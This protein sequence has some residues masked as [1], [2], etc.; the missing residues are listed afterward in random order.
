[1]IPCSPAPLE[2]EPWQREL[3]EAITDPQQLL[4]LLG[5][6]DRLSNAVQGTPAA[7][8]LRVPRY[9]AGLMRRGDPHDPLL[10]QVLPLRAEQYE[11]AGYRQD[12]VGDMAASLD[13]GILKK[14]RGRALLVTTGACAVHCRYCFRRHFPYA[15]QAL[16]RHWQAALHTLGQLPDIDELI[17]SGGDP[18]TLSDRRLRGLLEDAAQLSQLRRLRIHTRLPVVM[19]SRMTAALVRLLAESR[20]QTVVV[21]HANHPN[22]IT[23]ELG[24]A[25]QPLAATGVTLLN[26]SVLLKSVNDDADT[27][28]VLSESLF[29]IG[30]LPYYLH[31]LDPVAGAAH[32][33]VPLEQARRLLTA[34]RS[35]LPGYLVPRVVREEPGAGFKTPIAHLG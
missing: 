20:L 4:R 23:P 8:P 33:D 31:L 13:H 21:I 12:P 28:A 15:E 7:F 22:E 17:L 10:A 34:L 29:E 24:T 14:Y 9:F 19:P 1:M 16:L 11:Q 25:L 30:V 5:L 2:S 18:L 6:E 3:A 32:F 27:L 26:Q 35:R